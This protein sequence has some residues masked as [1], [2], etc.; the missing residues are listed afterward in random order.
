MILPRG[1]ILPHNLVILVHNSGMRWIFRDLKMF[2]ISVSWHKYLFPNGRTWCDMKDAKKETGALF[3]YNLAYTWPSGQLPFECQK[4]AK[5]WHFF[6]KNW[7]KLSFF[8]K[9]QV[10]G[11]F[12]TFKWQF[13]GG[14]GPYIWWQSGPLWE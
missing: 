12:L 6:K 5:N 8:F 14:S 9:C 10:F 4:I 2:V 7:Q 3:S 11:H 13:S 1:I